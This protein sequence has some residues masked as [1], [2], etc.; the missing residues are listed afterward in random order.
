M[1]ISQMLTILLPLRCGPHDVCTVHPVGQ[2]TD[3]LDPQ[4][5]DLVEEWVD[6]VEYLTK[7]SKF[8]NVSSLTLYFPNNFGAELTKVYYIGFK[9]EFTTVCYLLTLHASSIYA[10]VL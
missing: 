6:G 1:S 5:W 4:K 2:S 10:I 7:M 3:I 8:I 9:G